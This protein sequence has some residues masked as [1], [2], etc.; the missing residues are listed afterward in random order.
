MAKV[1]LSIMLSIIPV[2]LVADPK[3]Q[4]DDGTVFATTNDGRPLIVLEGD[5]GFEFSNNQVSEG[6]VIGVKPD[7]S[8]QASNNQIGSDKKT[9]K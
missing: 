6:T 2:S 4:I 9:A 7:G 8:L 5:P 1:I 3:P